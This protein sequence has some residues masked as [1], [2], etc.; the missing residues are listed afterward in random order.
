MNT[1]WTVMGIAMSCGLCLVPLFAVAQTESPKGQLP[2]ISGKT[3]IA[4]SELKW[5]PLPGIEGAQQALLVGEIG[6]AH[7]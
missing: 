1:N 3:L 4:A 6:R 2:K 5:V 7:V